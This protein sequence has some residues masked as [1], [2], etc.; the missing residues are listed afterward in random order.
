MASHV[1]EAGYISHLFDPF[2]RSG[3]C[4]SLDKINFVRATFRKFGAVCDRVRKNAEA[5]RNCCVIYPKS[6]YLHEPCLYKESWINK[7][8]EKVWHLFVCPLHFIAAVDNVWYYFLRLH[9]DSNGF[10]HLLRTLFL[11]KLYPI[12]Q[13][14]RGFT[15]FF[16]NYWIETQVININWIP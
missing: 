8:T 1:K 14:L 9:I 13:L 2:W 15:N 7:K 16:Q 4:D 6:K 12:K 10:P 11:S 5:S 3:G